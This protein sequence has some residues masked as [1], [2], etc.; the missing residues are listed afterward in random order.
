[1]RTK[2]LEQEQ[3][4]CREPWSCLRHQEL[5]DSKVRVRVSQLLVLQGT[6]TN[7]AQTPGRPARE[8]LG[9]PPTRL[10]P[11]GLK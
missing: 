5:G 4:I 9:T 2:G 8:S 10:F 1:M 6:R 7:P 11:F 3:K